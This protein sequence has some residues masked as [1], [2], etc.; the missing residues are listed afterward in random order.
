MSKFLE[1]TLKKRGCNEEMVNFIKSQWR[2]YDP[3][4][5]MKFNSYEGDYMFLSNMYPFRGQF[6]GI[7]VNSVDQIFFLQY[8]FK[9]KNEELIKEIQQCTGVRS[10]FLAK[11]KWRKYCEKIAKE[12]KKNGEELVNTSPGLETSVE[13]LEESISYLRNGWKVKY[14]YCSEFKHLLILSKKMCLKL[15]EVAPWDGLFGCC[16]NQ[17]TKL[18]E[19]CNLCGRFM[20][21]FRDKHIIIS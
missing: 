11:E 17:E 14:N 8:A 7:K 16:Y 20:N 2:Y 13:G 9:T 10:G 15:M 1:E 6:N 21:D 12:K 19:G 5:V 4:E 18:Y 3:K